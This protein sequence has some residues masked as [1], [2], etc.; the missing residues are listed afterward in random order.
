VD[1]IVPQVVACPASVEELSEIMRLASAE[2]LAVVPWGSGTK[3]GL[4]NVPPR[5]DLVV[6]LGRLGRVIDHE[7]ADLTAT[8]EGGAPLADVQAYLAK[9]GQF[10][11]LDPPDP[12]RA[13]IGGILATNSSGPRRVR[14]G[15][16]R[17]LVLG[18]RVVHADGTITKGGAKVVKNVTGYDMNKLYIGS[19]GTLGIIAEATFRISPRPGVEQ[20]W[21]APFPTGESAASAV[22]GVLDSTIVPSRVEILSSSAAQWLGNK[23][24]L[25]PRDGGFLF[26]ASVASVPEAVDAQIGALGRIAGHHGSLPGVVLEGETQ[27]A[28][29]TA[30]SGIGTAQGGDGIR[31]E[32]KVSVLP[33]KIIDV[34]RLGEECARSIGLRSAAISEAAS[35]IVKIHWTGDAELSDRPAPRIAKWIQTFRAAVERDGGSLVVQAAPTSVKRTIDVWGPVGNALA[36]MRALK[37]QFDPQGILNPGRFVG[38]I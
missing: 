17:D 15:A 20:T 30:V 14:Y 27:E 38:G 8:F 16:A 31:A 3:I 26:A 29:W 10:L 21:L 24:A 22:A 34:I 32:L 25:S 23:A 37:R 19:L 1:G 33:T 4:G 36:V 6:G 12:G 35:G 9:Q 2:G 11:P 5:V 7:P 28:F 18:I 13:T